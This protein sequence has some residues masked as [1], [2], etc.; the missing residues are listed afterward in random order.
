MIR[1]TVRRR[2]SYIMTKQLL[3]SSLAAA[4]LTTAAALPAAAQDSSAPVSLVNWGMRAPIGGTYEG[5]LDPSYGPDTL[6]I[7]FV[8]RGQVAASAVAFV[9]RS[10]DHVETI[11]DRGTF[12]PGVEVA[13]EFEPAIVAP[14]SVEV[15]AVT[16]NDGTTW[17]A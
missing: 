10:G 15:E 6:D 8:N 3:L 13:V 9:V 7:S 16:F 12:A 1:V 4:V 14:T 17:H 11:V 2:S 5:S